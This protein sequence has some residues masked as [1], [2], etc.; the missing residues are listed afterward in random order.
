[1]YDKI[2][3]ARKGALKKPLCALFGARIGIARGGR[4]PV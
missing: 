2:E 4:P 1:M 3:T